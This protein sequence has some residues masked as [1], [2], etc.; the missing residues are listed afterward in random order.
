MT[1]RNRPREASVMPARLNR[2]WKT[3]PR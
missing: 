2:F 3:T 1:L